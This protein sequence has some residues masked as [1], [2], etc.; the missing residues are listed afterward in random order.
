MIMMVTMMM[1]IVVMTTYPASIVT[2]EPPFGVTVT[3]PD[4]HMINGI[5]NINNYDDDYP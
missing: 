1:M 2:G 3:L 4:K 5:S